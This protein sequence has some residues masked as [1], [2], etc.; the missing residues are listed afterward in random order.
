MVNV[1]QDKYGE[2]KVTQVGNI[3]KIKAVN[4]NK[5]M[6]VPVDGGPLFA[7][8][9]GDPIPLPDDVPHSVDDDGKV[10]FIAP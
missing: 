10:Q 4:V 9:D 5:F 6:G 3:D 7:F 2:V 1:Y 8:M